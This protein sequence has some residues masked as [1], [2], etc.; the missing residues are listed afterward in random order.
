MRGNP[1]PRRLHGGR[2]ERPRRLH[3]DRLPRRQGRDLRGPAGAGGRAGRRGSGQDAL[4][5]L[6]QG[7]ECQGPLGADSEMKISELSLRFRGGTKNRNFHI[8]PRFPSRG[9]AVSPGVTPNCRQ[10][11]GVLSFS[12][13]TAR[14]PTVKTK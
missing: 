8:L 10:V 2:G 11:S 14:S 12:L 6:L 13:V 7:G 3:S 1:R 5:P 4:E 9:Q